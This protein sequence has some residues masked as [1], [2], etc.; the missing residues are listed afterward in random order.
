MKLYSGN[1]FKYYNASRIS[2]FDDL[3]VRFTQPEAF[4]DYQECTHEIIFSYDKDLL[5]QRAIDALLRKNKVVNEENIAIF[6]Q[7]MSGQYEKTANQSYCL[8]KNELGVLSL[9]KNPF[10][11]HLWSKYASHGFCVEFDCSSCFF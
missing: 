1:I 10:N 11:S 9:G 2:F 3:L 4:E 8:L 5:R 6:I 7:K